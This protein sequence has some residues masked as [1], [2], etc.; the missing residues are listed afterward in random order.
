MS[1]N[2]ILYDRNVSSYEQ[3][4]QNQVSSF[5]NMDYYDHKGHKYKWNGRRR[6]HVPKYSKIETGWKMFLW[7][8]FIGLHY[9]LNIRAMG[10]IFWNQPQTIGMY[11]QGW[12]SALGSYFGR[13][14]SL[15]RSSGQSKWLRAVYTA[16]T[17]RH[18]CDRKTSYISVWFGLFKAQTTL[19]TV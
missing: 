12:W 11:P 14:K 6:K 13:T 5:W 19:R 8:L 10:Q 17:S 18:W 16:N 4:C 3:P 2:F 1:W 9:A 15:T 7:T